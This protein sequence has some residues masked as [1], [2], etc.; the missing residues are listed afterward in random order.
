MGPSIGPISPGIATKLMALMSSDF[1]KV[2]T[3]VMRPTGNIMAPPQPCRIRK[4]T[5]Q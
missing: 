3:M 4:A 2:R 1:A 5:S